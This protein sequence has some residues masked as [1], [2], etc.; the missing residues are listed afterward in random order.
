MPDHDEHVRNDHRADLH[1]HEHQ[2]DGEVHSHA[3]HH[4]TDSPALHEHT[5][6]HGWER[7]TY[8]SSPIHDLDP[9]FKILAAVVLIIAVVVGAPMRPLEFALCLALL[10]ALTVLARVPLGS[11]LAR[12]AL[13]LPIAGSIA[14]FA[15]LGQV[16]TWT[17]A[18]VQQAY[19]EN[20]DVIWA[21]VSK[22][23]LS[24]YTVL[25]V[26]ATTPTPRLF[27]ALRA[28]RVPTIFIT[29]L[30]FL[31]RYIDVLGDQLRSLRRSV[32]SRGWNVRGWRLIVLYG[33]LAGSLFVRA[34]ERGERIYAAMLSRGYDGTLPTGETMTAAPADYLVL[35]MSVLVAAALALY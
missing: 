10:A 21:I 33:N 22:A 7:H 5:H 4:A 35:A 18:G 15:P 28:L 16:A 20:L 6:G 34:Y 27:A 8:V 12:S 9:R 31:Y 25:L 17:W 32:A 19:V 1:E 24:A 26:S 13:V 30:T 2:H 23:W 29:M 3:H 14:L 11:L